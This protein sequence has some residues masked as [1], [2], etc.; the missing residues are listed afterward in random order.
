[1]CPDQRAIDHVGG[2][3]ASRQFGQRLEHRIEHAGRDP[4]SVA[5]ENAVPLAIFIRQMPPLRS[6]S[7]DP[8][9]AFE[10]EAV[11]LC[12]TAPATALRQQQRTG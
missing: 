10:I 3:I 11:V 12:T 1:M 2:G 6:G 4:S 9:H 5:S 7:R 8:H